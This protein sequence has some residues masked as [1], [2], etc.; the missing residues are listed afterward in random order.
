QTARGALLEMQASQTAVDEL[1]TEQIEDIYAL[2]TGCYTFTLPLTLAARCAGSEPAGLEAIGRPAGI[3]F[4]L[5]NDL[6]SL[7]RW[8]ET[9]LLPDDIR[10]RRRIWPLVYA[11]SQDQLHTESTRTAV[12]RAVGKFAGQVLERVDHLP[13]T[14]DLLR[15]FL[16]R[17]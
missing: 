12:R 6:N 15:K 10:D 16:V 17:H 1:N 5:Q 9:G 11:G 13:F 3:A 2:K 7:Q 4:Q 8:Q 14:N